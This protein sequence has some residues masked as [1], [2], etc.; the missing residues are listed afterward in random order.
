MAR[1][2]IMPHRVPSSKSVIWGSWLRRTSDFSAPLPT[3]VEGWDYAQ[4]LDVEAEIHLDA[5]EFVRST[6]LDLSGVAIVATADCPSTSQRFVTQVEWDE[7]VAQDTPV[8]AIHIPAGSAANDISLA[9]HIILRSPPESGDDFVAKRPGARL[10]SSPV[11]R[12]YLEGSASRFPTE[13]LS[14]S[15]AQMEEAAWTV[16]VRFDDLRESFAG[17]VRLLLNSDHPVG[18]GLASMD[19][20]I[21]GAVGSF[22]RVDIV[23]ALIGVVSDHL[24][25]TGF[26]TVPLDEDSVGAIVSELCV[27]YM[28]RDFVSIAELRRSDPERYERVLQEGVGITV[29]ATR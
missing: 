27:H 26:D 10:L 18:R 16:R 7:L 23:R 14:F 1:I 17:S 9:A 15:S 4:S 5:S 22:L 21:Y 28:G 13:A 3:L 29:G 8:V 6:G 20:T 2:R 12:V 24:A 11:T 19:E 25:D